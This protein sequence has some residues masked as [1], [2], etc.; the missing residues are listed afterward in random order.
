M[1]TDTER[2]RVEEIRAE[3]DTMKKWCNDP[4]MPPEREPPFG[5]D[6]RAF[7]NH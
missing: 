1:L 4:V 6:R 3:S 5:I 7:L 2:K